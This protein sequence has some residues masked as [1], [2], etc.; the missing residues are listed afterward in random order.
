MNVRVTH[1]C[2]EIVQIILEA[3]YAHVNLGTQVSYLQIISVV[4]QKYARMVIKKC[5]HMY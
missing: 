4:F 1:V 2:M 3:L 5:E